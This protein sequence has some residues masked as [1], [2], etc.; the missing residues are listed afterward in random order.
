MCG[1]VP[2]DRRID[3]RLLDAVIFLVIEFV[4]VAGIAVAV[5]VRG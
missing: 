3:G 5:V 1:V 2:Q 4:I